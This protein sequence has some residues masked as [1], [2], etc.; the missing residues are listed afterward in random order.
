MDCYINVLNNNNSNKDNSHSYC[1]LCGILYIV[2]Q[3]QT[4]VAA[5]FLC[6]RL[7]LFD[8]SGYTVLLMVILLLLFLLIAAVITMAT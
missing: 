1:H 6:R 4:A 2:M 5:D 3:V 7:L 8:S